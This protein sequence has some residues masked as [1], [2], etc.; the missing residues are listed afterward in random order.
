MHTNMSAKYAP[1]APLLP[2]RPASH[3][4]IRQPRMVPHASSIVAYEAICAPLLFARK[5]TD[6]GTYTDPAH[7]PTIEMKSSAEFT[8]V[9]RRYSGENSAGNES[10]A[11]QLRS[12]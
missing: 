12:S 1:S 5:R 9:R 4:R 6:D 3:G 2:S 7:S 11:D 8:S 10:R